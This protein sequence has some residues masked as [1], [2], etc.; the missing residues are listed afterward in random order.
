MRFDEEDEQSRK[1]KDNLVKKLRTENSQLKIKLEQTKDE[2][3]DAKDNFVTFK[4]DARGSGDVIS[5]SNKKMRQDED[6]W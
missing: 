1:E 4:E 3:Y 2:L 5:L 6:V